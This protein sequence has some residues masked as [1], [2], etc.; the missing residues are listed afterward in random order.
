MR[1]WVVAAV[2]GALGLGV[3]PGSAS[4]AP[5]ITS[6]VGPQLHSIDRLAFAPDGRLVVADNQGAM[7]YALDLERPA[8]APGVQGVEGLDR[9][10]AAMMAADRVAF[11]DMVVDPRSGQAYVAAIRASGES[12]LFRVNGAGEIKPVPLS[13]VR[14]SAVTLPNV[15]PLVP[16]YRSPREDT[17]TSMAFDGGR[18][19]VAGLSNEEFSSKLRAVPYPF[20]GAGA[21]TSVEVYHTSHGELETR[22]PIYTLMPMRFGDSAEMLAAY[23]CTPLVRLKETDLTDGAEVR[24]TNIAEMGRHNRP[25]TMIRYVKDGQ[26]FVLMSNTRRGLLRLPTSAI[27]SAQ[28]IPYEPTSIDTRDLGAHRVRGWD[29]VEWIALAGDGRLAALIRETDGSMDL[30]VAP[31]P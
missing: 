3:L 2:A 14:Y 9:K 7:L 5:G 28:T 30:K 8:D 21:G 27:L 15:R 29:D 17:V 10:V 22:S 31:L 12:G 18:L 6:G 19:Y 26:D 13:G 16:G 11:T 4:E 25:L 23:I 1:M 24:G 20:R